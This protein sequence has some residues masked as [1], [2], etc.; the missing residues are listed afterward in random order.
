M[1]KHVF[2]GVFFC[3]TLYSIGQGCCSGGS[4]SPIAGGSSQGVLSENQIEIS[5][6]YQYVSS[7]TF[8]VKDHDTTRMFESLKSDYIYTRLAYGISKKLSFLVEVGYFLKGRKI[9][10]DNIETL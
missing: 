9:G 6:N 5:S 4:G 3:T 2:L 10:L 1:I 8:M 7:N